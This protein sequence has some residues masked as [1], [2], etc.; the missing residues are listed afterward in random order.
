MNPKYA[1]ILDCGSI[2]LWDSISHIIMHMEDDPQVGGACGEIECL[3]PEKKEHTKEISFFESVMLRAQYVE[4]KLSHYLDKSMETLFG[5][6]S[7]LPGAF[8]TFR[9]ECIN[10]RPLHEFLRGA[11][12]EFGDISYIRTCASANKYLA[13]DRIM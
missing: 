4:Y 2:P 1:Q 3:V 9:W 6:V 5:F 12:D 10:G 8:S 13:E 7:V 11:N